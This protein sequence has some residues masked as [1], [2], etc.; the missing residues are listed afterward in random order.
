MKKPQAYGAKRGNGRLSVRRWSKRQRHSRAPCDQIS[1]DLARHARSRR[2]ADQASSRPDNSAPPR[3]RT[4][5]RRKPKRRWSRRACLSTERKRSESLL[6]TRCCCSWS[7]SVPGFAA[8]ERSMA[9]RWASLRA[10]PIARRKATGNGPV[11]CWASPHGYFLCVD[12]TPCERLRTLRSGH[13]A[14]RSCRT[15]PADDAIWAR[16]W[17]SNLAYRSLALWRLAIPKRL[18][19]ILTMR[20]K[21]RAKLATMQH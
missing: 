19:K 16:R 15:S 11:S 8:L 20:S 13:R 4:M 6:K 9:K 2:R 1:C 5:P 12:R 7:S 18:E 14:L 17:G 10:I 21:M 3:E